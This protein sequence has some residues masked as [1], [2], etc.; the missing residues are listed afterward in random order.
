[1]IDPQAMAGAEPLPAEF[2]FLPASAAPPASLAQAAALARTQAI[3][4][5]AA[6]LAS[7]VVNETDYY[8]ALAQHLGVD[9]ISGAADLGAGARCPHSI[10][11][12]IA[13][14]GAGAGPR[15]LVAPRGDLLAS[16]LRHRR[17]GEAM[18]GTI[19]IT[20]PANLSQLMRANAQSTIARE[21]SLALRSCRPGAASARRNV[22]SP[23]P[24]SRSPPSPAR[25]RRIPAGR[26]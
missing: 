12:G 26:S 9:F 21:A 10:H 3:A 5:E 14:L 7:G 17:G 25:S 16:L 4:P 22:W 20:T 24:P 6:L 8:R 13:P 1:M 23:A 2:A 15:W 11:A 19:A 18:S